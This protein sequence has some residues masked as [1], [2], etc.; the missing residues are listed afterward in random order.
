MNALQLFRFVAN[1]QRQRGWGRSLRA[2]VTHWYGE[3]PAAEVAA[4]ILK[5]PEHEG[6][7]H[8]DLL[9][10]AHPKPA[11]PAH[12]ALF[13][14]VANGDLGHLATPGLVAGE[15]RQV[16]AVERL[17]RT[18]EEQEA[19]R[20]VEHYS[21]THEMIPEDWKSAAAIQEILLTGM[22]YAELVEHL[23]EFADSGLLGEESPS[24]ALVVIRLIDQ[25]RAK[26]SGLTRQH[27]TRAREEY[28]RH[29]RAI[30][31]VL[32]ALDVAQASAC[33]P[34]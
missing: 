27:L 4:D 17:K 28:A 1:A 10:L 3:R 30:R 13:Q 11:T 31:V 14:W 21:L 34:E 26:N 7:S 18:R 16:Y 19:L 29:P 15:L 24:T 22:S 6:W 2:I 33:G 23:T 9:R 5:C 12:N 25:R 8:R 32:D 20:L